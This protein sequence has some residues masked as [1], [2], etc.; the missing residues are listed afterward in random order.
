MR[1]TKWNALAFLF[2]GA[3]ILAACG[4]Q[5]GDSADPTDA[6]PDAPGSD[7]PGTSA[8]PTDDG[9]TSA[10]T[11]TY[12]IDGQLTTLSNANND[13]PTTEAFGFIG[14]ALYGYD[15]ALTPVPDLAADLCEVSEDDL[16]WTCTLVD[17]IFHNCDP[18][19]AADVAFTYEVAKSENCR[20]NPSVCLGPFLESAEAIDETT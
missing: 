8:A 1:R 3:L 4:T 17:A 19:T 6:P 20:F 13:V 18:V 11:I 10:G 15:P 5:P 9:S 16:V 12:A 7:D 14:A 2:S